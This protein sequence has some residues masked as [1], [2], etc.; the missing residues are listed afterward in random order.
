M[1]LNALQIQYYLG[2][3]ISLPLLPVLYYQGKSIRKKVPRLPEAS[4]TKGTAKALNS[5]NSST[6]QLITLGESTIAG[7]GVATHEEGFTGSLAKSLA[8]QYHCSVDWEVFARSGYTA[9]QVHQ[10]LVG[11]ITPQKADLIVIGLGGNDAFTLNN[12]K[13]WA[14]DCMSLITHLKDKYPEATLYFCNMP[15]IKAF[16]AFTKPI[17]WVI[18]NLVELLGKSLQEKVKELSGV[19]YNSEVIQLETWLERY[20][21]DH[22]PE[23]LFSDGVHPAKITYQTWGRDMA[24]FIK[25]KSP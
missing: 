2:G 10:K 19:H 3:L 12:P 21:I 1:K 6:L 16:P 11:K 8:K 25:Q 18:G 4:G 24:A 13:S 9:K 22:T 17:Q 15:P 7:V 14:N 5:E 23:E 20:A